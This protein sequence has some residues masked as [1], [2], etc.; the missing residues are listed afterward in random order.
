M[1]DQFITN[2]QDKVKLDFIPK[3]KELDSLNVIP[4]FNQLQLAVSPSSLS[5]ITED[6]PQLIR[7]MSELPLFNSQAQ[8]AL[9]FD[10]NDP[11]STDLTKDDVLEIISYLSDHEG[12]T[13]LKVKGLD[14]NGTSV[15]LDF[16][17]AFITHKTEITTRNKFIDEAS[18]LASL[19]GALTEY[20]SL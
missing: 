15:L 16:G 11:N 10:L 18:A 9:N 17:N 3:E 14:S 5:D 1:L 4:I 6:T 13:V 12:C 8:L 2:R 7:G 19:K 20:L